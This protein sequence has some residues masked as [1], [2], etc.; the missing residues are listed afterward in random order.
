M[1]FNLANVAAIGRRH[2][3]YHSHYHH[4]GYHQYGSTGGSMVWLWITIAL[5]A[6][7]ALAIWAFKR[8]T[9]HS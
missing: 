7:V 4:Y 2:G 3:T 5:I 9:A 6:V 8:S 1:A